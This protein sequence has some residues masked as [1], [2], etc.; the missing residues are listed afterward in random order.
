MSTI[1]FEVIHHK[2]AIRDQT[3]FLVLQPSAPLP[4]PVHVSVQ[5]DDTV[6][7][8]SQELEYFHSSANNQVG[9]E[10]ARKPGTIMF[11]DA[12]GHLLGSMVLSSAL[13]AASPRVTRPEDSRDAEPGDAMAPAQDGHPDDASGDNEP[14]SGGPGN[15]A[16]QAR[17][18]R[19]ERTAARSVRGEHLWAIIKRSADGLSYPRFDRFVELAFC[20]RP[21]D[22]NR[23][24]QRVKDAL[25]GNNEAGNREASALEPLRETRDAGLLF[26]GDSYDRLKVA[27]EVFL[28]VNASV[29]PPQELSLVDRTADGDD[30]HAYLGDD[31]TLP[32]LRIVYDR[33]GIRPPN[34]LRSQAVELGAER[35]RE[36]LERKTHEPCMIELIWSYWHE[37]A[38]QVQAMAAIT[39]RFQNRRA[40]GDRD[41]LAALEI[42]PLRGLNHVLWKHVQGESDRL[43]VLRRAHE[44]H[45]EYGFSLH[46]KAVAPQRP[47]DCRSKFLE[48]FHN[49]LYRCV[50]FYKEDDD[51][52]HCADGFPVLNALKETHYVLSQG[53]HNQ[54]GDLPFTA[55]QEMLV[56]Q[57]ILSRP[58]M[59]EFLGSRPM[60]AYPE[61]WMDRVDTVKTL[62]G[63]SGTSCLHFHDLAVYGE[64]LLLSI[65][66]HYWSKINLPD[67]GKQWARAW[68]PEVQGYIHAIRAT[69]GLDLSAKITS[70]RDEA[71][72]YLSP[73]VHLQRRLTSLSTAR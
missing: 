30:L 49:L 19:L 23:L 50:E 38:M 21:R 61:P 45:H 72:R 69:L 67:E 25:L 17:V 20:D 51:T 68:R 60:V 48:A 33:L 14:G 57:W 28:L 43:S 42:D 15:G 24:E 1:K 46:G 66:W 40:P 53:A 36:M 16:A 2:T 6:I 10:L 27:A 70:S 5:H 59:R 12:S 35:C 63:W 32:Y 47:A 71:E 52:T 58:E 65:R 18:V 64:Q 26:R 9:I 31:T 4:T 11:R 55:R 29:R 73:S 39:Q 56:E 41:P 34:L 8:A 37:E 13:V 3:V 44:Y 22:G 54:F 62:K 7:H